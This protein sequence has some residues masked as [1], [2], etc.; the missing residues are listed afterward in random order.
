[1]TK[2]ISM[3]WLCEAESKGPHDASSK[4]MEGSI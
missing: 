4:K 1:M 2:A 3:C